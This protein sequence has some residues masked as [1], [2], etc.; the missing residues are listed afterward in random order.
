[1]KIVIIKDAFFPQNVGG[2]E[3]SAHCM[4]NA[5]VNLGHDVVVY[6]D[7]RSVWKCKRLGWS[8]SYKHSSIVVPLP[9]FLKNFLEK[10]LP[11]I[12][13]EIHFFTLLPKLLKDRPDVIQIVHLWPWVCI[14]GKI[15]KR[16]RI[17]NVVRGVGDDIQVSEG[18]GYGIGRENHRKKLVQEGLRDADKAIAISETVKK[19]YLEAGVR[20]SKIKIIEPGVDNK[21][22]KLANFDRTKVR[23]KW[24]LPLDKYLVISVGRNHP[25]KGFVEL[26]DVCK[27][28]HQKRN[29]IAI[30]VVGRDTESLLKEAIGQGIFDNFY[31]IPEISNSNEKFLGSFPSRDLVELYKA[32]DLF[33]YPSYMETYANVAVEAMAANLP[34]V[35]TDAPGCFE[36]VK[37]EIDGLIVKVKDNISMSQSIISI[38]DNQELNLRLKRN[39]KVKAK[40]QDWNSISENYLSVYKSF[41]E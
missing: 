39:G 40:K 19:L 11:T 10:Y 4:A 33:A 18:I 36:T 7:F 27:I 15:K 14:V 37:H 22:Y 30:L 41:E 20:E 21:A 6:S 38:I 8:F 31:T 13:K 34:V 12:W 25:K 24:N 26:V 28:I 29:D 16:L 17:P 35:I 3:I 5:L 23:Q 2:A 9:F 1:M 32:S